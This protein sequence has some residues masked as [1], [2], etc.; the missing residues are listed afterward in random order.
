MGEERWPLSASNFWRRT[1]AI[2]HATSGNLAQR[3]IDDTDSLTVHGYLALSR[4]RRLAYRLYRH[5]A[6]MFGIDPLYLFVVQYRLPVGMMLRGW[7]PW[8]STM[9]TNVALEAVI[10]IVISFVGL[11]TFLVIQMPIIALAAS[12]GVWLFLAVLCAAP[13]RGHLLD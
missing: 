12:A 4:R 3:G 7:Q 5:P 11:K 6:V 2:H 1:H 10:A 9:A 13:I 8:L